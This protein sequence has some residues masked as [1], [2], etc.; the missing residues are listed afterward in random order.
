[1]LPMRSSWIVAMVANRL[2]RTDSGADQGRTHF[3]SRIVVL[4]IALILVRSGDQTTGTA[5]VEIFS[6]N[7]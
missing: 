3:W 7:Q 6:V 2:K 5:L 1:M 4:A